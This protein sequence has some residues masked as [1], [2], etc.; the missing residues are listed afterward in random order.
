MLRIVVAVAVWMIVLAIP[1]RAD[2]TEVLRDVETA[3]MQDVGGV[4]VDPLYREQVIRQ[5]ETLIRQHRAQFD[6]SQFF[7]LVDRN[8]A[9]QK[10]F[11]GFY[12]C[13]TERVAIVGADK[14][15][16]GNPARRG[17]FETPV[18]VFE[19]TPVNMSY[20]ALGTKNSKGW[21]GLGRKGSRVWDL[22]WQ[23]TVRGRGEPMDIRL[24]VHATDPDF[25]EPRL[26]GVDSKGCIR[27]SER[28][29]RFLDY[30]G[31]LDREFEASPRARYVLLAGRAPLPFQGAF[32]VVID[33]GS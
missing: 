18:G 15:S 28:F 4:S 5:A 27:V 17:F 13:V 2:Q 3:F 12:D 19:N 11:L 31:I 10:V 6:A 16:T 1:A 7:L 26:G 32:V 24:L 23:R 20:R 9:E 14:T 33:S 8:H 21:R 25:G 22:G 30:R 29:N